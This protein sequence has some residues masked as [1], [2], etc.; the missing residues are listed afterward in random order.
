MAFIP[1]INVAQ[2]ELRFLVGTTR[3]ENV[4]T[5]LKPTGIEAADL[6]PL[7]VAIGTW[8][9]TYIRGL[10]RVGT[11]MNEVYARDLTSEFASAYAD[12]SRTGQA[13]TDS[14]NPQMP[15]NVTMC[16]S[17]RT[18]IP[19][20]SYRGRN[21]TIAPAGTQITGTP[22]YFQTT[23]RTNYQTAYRRLLVGGGSLPAEWLWVV[24]SRY[25]NKAPRAYGVATIIQDVPL[26]NMW[27]DSQRRR[28]QR[29]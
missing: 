27:P 21:Y 16:I 9:Y 28:L 22:A 4:L 12:T 3:V 6:P 2:V 11:I 7:T 23:H 26:P 25:H 19:G 14:G 15:L 8:W 17:F 5:F 20:R 24:V 29:F 13:G 10:Q 18:G 1:C